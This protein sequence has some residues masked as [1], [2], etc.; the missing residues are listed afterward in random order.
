MAK[1]KYLIRILLFF[2]I[3]VLIDICFGKAFDYM[4]SHANGGDTKA[5]YDLLMKDQYDIIILG[6]SRATHH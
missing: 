2:V 3:I 6:S 5:T 4:V 1:K